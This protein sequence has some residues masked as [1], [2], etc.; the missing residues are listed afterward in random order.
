VGQARDS[1]DDKG[2][3]LPGLVIASVSSAATAV[4]V[5]ALWKPGTV[6]SAAVTPVLMTLFAEALRRP[7]ERVVVRTGGGGH[8]ATIDA[9][10]PRRR[11]GRA[12]AAGL[13]AFALGPPA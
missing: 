12:V 13:A 8:H 3:S 9:E 1:S 2:L 7:A 10:R 5:H 6:L 11:W 4:V